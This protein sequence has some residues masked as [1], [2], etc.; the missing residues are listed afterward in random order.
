MDSKHN[1]FAIVG[2]GGYIAPRHLR[3]I[4]S[5]GGELIASCDVSDSVGIIDSYFPEA[6]F[7]TDPDAFFGALRRS[8]PDYLTV[9]TPNYLHCRHSVGGLDAGANVICEKPIVLTCAEHRLLSERQRLSGRKVSP[10]LQMRLHPEAARIKERLL[11]SPDDRIHDIDLTYITP[12]GRW[13]AASWKGRAEESGGVLTNIGVHFVDLLHWL[14][15]R[16]RS[17]VLHR[18]T[19]DSI[20][21]LFVLERAQV[22]FLLSVNPSHVPRNHAGAYRSLVIDGEPFDF[23]AGF[24]DLHDL[25]YAEILAG[26]GFTL[27]DTL[28]AV[29]TV[30]TVRTLPVSPLVGSYHPLLTELPEVFRSQKF[31][32]L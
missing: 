2:V 14:F 8:V 21:G 23:S 30:E 29:E 25:S 5:V 31:V 17:I 16:M 27:D 15:G 24:A 9:C 19:P 6:D 13:Y 20:A 32:A 11:A 28:A 22:R 7:T 18:S 1:R 12:R 26:R 3:A 4:R 10:I